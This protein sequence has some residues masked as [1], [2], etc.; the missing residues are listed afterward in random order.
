V[1]EEK[2]VSSQQKLK[3]N[4]NPKVISE[5]ITSTKEKMGPVLV[6]IMHG[7]EKVTVE[8]WIQIIRKSKNELVFRT[9]TQNVPMVHSL[10]GSREHVNV[11][12]PS[13]LVFFQ[14]RVKQLTPDG[15]L[16]LSIPDMIAHVD[17]RKHLRITTN[18]SILT[19]IS[20]YKSFFSHKVNTQLFKKSCFDIGAGGLSFVISKM[21]GKYFNIGDKIVG[22]VLQLGENKI[23]VDATIVNVL[24]I[25]P[26]NFNKL[27]Y[28]GQKIC[29]KFDKVN[30][31]YKETLE[32]FIFKYYKVQPLAV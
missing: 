16:T 9:R 23:E 7:E 30:A 5:L 22:I 17:R 31:I 10:V 19:E 14:T 2:M 18:P 24:A 3:E 11:F 4:R 25:E 28:K 15:E 29:L 32:M 13:D 12:F 26:D 6:W 1:K 20:F 21:E 8:M 27:V